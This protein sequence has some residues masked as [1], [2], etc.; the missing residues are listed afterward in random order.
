MKIPV[1]TT[2]ILEMLSIN[3]PEEMK[4]RFKNQVLIRGFGV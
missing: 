3:I 1:Q 4:I 2:D